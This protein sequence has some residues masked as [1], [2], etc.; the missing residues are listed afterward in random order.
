MLAEMLEEGYHIAILRVLSNVLPYFYQH[1]KYL[2]D[3]T[4][5][6]CIYLHAIPSEYLDDTDQSGSSMMMSFT[7]LYL[8]L[9]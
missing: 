9:P 5:Y 1:A 6:V 8:A 3:S 7:L 2:V 4:P